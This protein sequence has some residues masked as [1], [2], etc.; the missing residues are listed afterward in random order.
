[1]GVGSENTLLRLGLGLG[2][3][4]IASGFVGP[5]VDAAHRSRRRAGLAL[6]VPGL[7]V[8]LVAYMATRQ[9]AYPIQGDTGLGTGFLIGAV[10]ALV[11]G[12]TGFAGRTDAGGLM[13]CAVGAALVATCAA[14][15][16]FP[17]FPVPALAGLPFGMGIAL[18]WVDGDEPEA[19]LGRAVAAGVLALAA[20][21]A[22]CLLAIS[23]YEGFSEA[24]R[25]T[26]SGKVWWVFPV[27]I[28]GA[29]V[30]GLL[31]TRLLPRRTWAA[32]IGSGV[33]GG[34]VVLL[35]VGLLRGAAAAGGPASGWAIYGP[36][37][38]PVLGGWVS[39]LI[40]FCANEA[41]QA[42]VSTP[43]SPVDGPGAPAPKN[44]KPETETTS[45]SA[46]PI[47]GVLVL[48]AL[49][50][51]AYRSPISSVLAPESDRAL[52]GYGLGLAALGF[53][54]A[55][56]V[57]L[58]DAAWRAHRL[59]LAAGL[60]L[61]IAALF[62]VFYM[63]YDLDDSGIRL[64]AHYTLIGMMAGAVAPISLALAAQ[65]FGKTGVR[66]IARGLLLGLIAAGLP[67]LLVLFWGVRAG[68][69]LLVGLVAGLGFVIFTQM[70]EPRATDG[71]AG[72]IAAALPVIPT[73]LVALVTVLALTPLDYYASQFPRGLRIGA[74]V[75]I[76]FALP[77]W[78][79]VT[80]RQGA[81]GQRSGL[82]G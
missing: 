47:L 57:C 53:L 3:L 19:D 73:L 78:A 67:A 56:P 63:R 40:L 41:R 35:L 36:L 79:A 81:G 68:G 14:F 58:S 30:L 60:A 5:G 70:L 10:A 48:L 72:R 37:T 16:L 15:L 21:S 31:T 43:E 45:A 49:L 77:V 4:G 39:G 33:V 64:A 32:G 65:S 22:S 59:H 12:L 62:R 9:H 24:Q 69:G 2:L 50:G 52:S 1:M 38:L 29:V 7:L 34:V 71:P 46:T 61:V 27:A 6:M 23:R 26:I 8:A 75:L 44:S 20:L 13:T 18:L 25:L 76:V 28:C 42:E 17:G 66:N 11:V 74:V 51:A 82:R 80:A 55:S 54:L